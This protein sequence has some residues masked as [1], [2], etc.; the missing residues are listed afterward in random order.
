MSVLNKDQLKALADFYEFVTDPPLNVG[1]MPSN[2][3]YGMDTASGESGTVYALVHNGIFSEITEEEFRKDQG[4]A[5][6]SKEGASKP[7]IPEEIF[8]WIADQAEDYAVFEKN[9]PAGKFPTYKAGAIAM[10]HKLQE[11]QLTIQDYKDALADKDNLTRDIDVILHGDGAA[12]QASLCDLVGPIQKIAS[13]LSS[14]TALLEGKNLEIA[15]L[16]DE[17]KE[18]EARY[19]RSVE[20]LTEFRMVMLPDLLPKGSDAREEMVRLLKKYP[21]DK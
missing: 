4:K 1:D 17:T 13:H 2:P 6:P 7:P 5:S 11:D 12:R 3:V 8:Q 15:G 16:R 18:A 21:M 20:I 19:V 10:Y 9:K 14:M